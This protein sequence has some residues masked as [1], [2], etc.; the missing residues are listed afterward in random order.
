[1]FKQLLFWA[2]NQ[3]NH[4]FR[5][6]LA[7]QETL[8]DFHGDKAKKIFFWEKNKKTVFSTPPIPNIF[9]RK[10]QGLVL[11]LVELIDAKGIN[12]SQWLSGCRT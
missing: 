12:V 4:Q 11:G 5:P 1:M 9:S 2:G 7:T 8:T 10:Y 6:I 3:G